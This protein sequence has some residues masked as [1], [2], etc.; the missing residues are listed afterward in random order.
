MLSQGKFKS[1]IFHLFDRLILLLT[2]GLLT[3]QIPNRERPGYDQMSKLVLKNP[4]VKNIIARALVKK[5]GDA[6][7]IGDTEWDRGLRSDVVFQLV[8]GVYLDQPPSNVKIQGT[9]NADFMNRAAHH[10]IMAYRR[11]KVLP[12]ML[13]FNIKVTTIHTNDK[14]KADGFCAFSLPC[15]YWAKGCYLVNASNAATYQDQ[16]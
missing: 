4:L 11:Y 12:I 6:Y 10:C 16:H 2:G 3:S 15:E 8:H 7:K 14:P 1:H 5:D 13:I 9:V